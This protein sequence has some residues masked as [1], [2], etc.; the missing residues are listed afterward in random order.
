MKKLSVLLVSTALA[1]SM[2]QAKDKDFGVGVEA[3]NLTVGKNNI[4]VSIK[5]KTIPVYN[6]A[7]KLQ[8]YQPNKKIST[9]TTNKVNGAGN[10][11]FSVNLPQAGTYNYLL[12]F[13]RNGGVNHVR[14][15][16][17]EV[18]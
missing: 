18:R 10:Y 7:L 15:G 5:S 1:A 8:V 2:A 6:A 11:T 9:Y 16:D 17:F 12:S 4:D 3:D 13:K 14:R